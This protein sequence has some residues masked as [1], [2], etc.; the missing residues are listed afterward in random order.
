MT[1]KILC[2]LLCCLAALSLV[3]CGRGTEDDSQDLTA[4]FQALTAEGEK[5]FW[6]YHD[7]ANEDLEV[8]ITAAPIARSFYPVGRFVS[9]EEM[10]Q[11]SEQVFSRRFCE[12]VLYPIG[13]DETTFGTV[14]FAD[15]DGM[16][17]CN[18]D[19]GG[20]GWDYRM[21]EE[22]SWVSQDEVQA[23]F[24]VMVEDVLQ[25]ETVPMEFRL[26]WE[27]GHWKLDTWFTYGQ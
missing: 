11:A 5:V 9:I 13:F 16:L 18:P 2:L 17:C 1:K 4:T 7:P 23:V 25:G 3:A 6:W 21:T 24:S 10:K 8:D 14:H 26:I 20:M 27:D 12:E 19:V 15:I 22:I